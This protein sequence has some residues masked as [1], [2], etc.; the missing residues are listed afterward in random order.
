MSSV[1]VRELRAGLA[2]DGFPVASLTNKIPNVIKRS[3]DL[4]DIHIP[5]TLGVSS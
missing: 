2:L 1:P 4:Y 5:F 3:T